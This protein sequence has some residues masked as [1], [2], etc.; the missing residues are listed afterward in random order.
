M[1]KLLKETVMLNY[2][3]PQIQELIND[4]GWRDLGEKDRI[5]SIY[6]FVRDKI[7]FGY[8]KN[9]DIKATDV[10]NDEYGQCNTKGILFMALL[11]AVGVACRIHAFYVD[12]AVQ[13]GAMKNIY[14]ILAP[15]EI[16]HSWVEI[17]Y[18]RKWFNLEGFILDVNYLSKLQ[19]KF[20]NCNGSFCGYGVAISDFQNPQIEWNENDTYIQKDAI[21][22]DLGVFDSPDDLFTVEKQEVSRFKLF[23]FENV[24]R[25]LMNNNVQRVRSSK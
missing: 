12:K 25:H 14:Y 15:K 16:L 18:N 5:L 8:N 20:K 9:D 19:K 24:I 10:L 2:N 23:M 17:Y 3:S 6:N 7:S 1:E 11:R 13:K 22:R 4:K 21:T